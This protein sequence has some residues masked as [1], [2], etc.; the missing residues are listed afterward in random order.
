VFMESRGSGG[1]SP[2]AGKPPLIRRARV[3]LGS[4]LFLVVFLCWAPSPSPG[5][6]YFVPLGSQVFPISLRNLKPPR[7]PW[8][9]WNDFLLPTYTLHKALTQADFKDVVALFSTWPMKAS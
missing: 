4:S 7:F 3:L 1:E 9:E 8:T 6:F 2:L 5:T